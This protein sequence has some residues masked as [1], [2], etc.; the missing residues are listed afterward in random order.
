MAGRSRKARSTSSTRRQD[1]EYFAGLL[2]ADGH[3]AL[4]Y[5]GGMDPQLRARTEE[6]FAVGEVGVVVSTNAFGLGVDKPDVALVLHLEMPQS[7]EDYVQETGR[8]ARGASDGTGPAVGTCVLLSTPGD[9]RIHSYFAKSAAPDIGVV[10]RVWESLAGCGRGTQAEMARRAGCDPDEVDPALLYLE[11]HGPVRR[12]PDAVERCIVTVP[13]NWRDRMNAAG[14]PP[15]RGS[16]LAEAVGEAVRFGAEPFNLQKMGEGRWDIDEIE[17]LLF[18]ADR[19]EILTVRVIE[20]A[21]AVDLEADR[22]PDWD[23]IE[24]SLDR[25]PERAAA[26]SQQAKDFAR[27]RTSCRRNRMLDYL[28]ASRA[29]EPCGACDVCDP[30][31]GRTTRSPASRWPRPYRSSR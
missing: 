12:R 23:S 27:N 14:W 9:C 24:R 17:E 13:P 4:A 6:A 20:Y 3:S 22:E 28:G 21:V 8:A 31:P 30:G 1:T 18:A 15:D 19:D 7:V 29:P 2:R 16:R 11:I 25:Q 26:R 5:H 10:R